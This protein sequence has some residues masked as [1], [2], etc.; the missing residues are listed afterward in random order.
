MN[1]STV[2]FDSFSSS[3]RKLTISVIP[4]NFD[5]NYKQESSVD[6]Q[7][8]NFALISELFYYCTA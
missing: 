2:K 8:V 6:T 3:T 1:K 5:L 7:T 4:C